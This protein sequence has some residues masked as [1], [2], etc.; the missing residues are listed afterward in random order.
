MQAF[1]DGKE[2][3]TAGAV[4]L[5]DA[6]N[7]RFDPRAKLL[8]A[9]Y[10]SALAAIDPDTMRVR[11]RIALAGHPESFQLDG[12]GRFIYG[13]ADQAHELRFATAR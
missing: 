7:L 3:T 11:Q 12:A 2:P 5:E 6:D 13:N 8:Y 9:G 10:G 4:D 1:E